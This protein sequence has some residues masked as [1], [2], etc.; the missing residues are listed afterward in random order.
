[1]F[2]LVKAGDL[3]TKASRLFDLLNL[4][5]SLMY[6]GGL[7]MAGILLRLHLAESRIIKQFLITR[8]R[9]HRKLIDLTLRITRWKLNI[10]IHLC[11]KRERARVGRKNLMMLLGNPSGHFP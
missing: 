11:L 7:R 3:R 9:L 6:V 8:H 10:Y 1:M 5:L 4:V 2:I